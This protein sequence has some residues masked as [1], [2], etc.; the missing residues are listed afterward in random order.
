VRNYSELFPSAL[1]NSYRDLRLPVQ[2]VVEAP[3]GTVEKRRGTLPRV[4]QFW[5]YGMTW[6]LP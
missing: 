2:I 5:M 6:V 4:G 1:K 3:E